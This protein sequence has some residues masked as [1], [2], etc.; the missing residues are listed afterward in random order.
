M[1]W[2]LFGCWLRMAWGWFG[3]VGRKG[4]RMKCLESEEGTGERRVWRRI[5]GRVWGNNIPGTD[6]LGNYQSGVVGCG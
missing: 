4:M 6:S 2:V 5:W 1:V 3:G